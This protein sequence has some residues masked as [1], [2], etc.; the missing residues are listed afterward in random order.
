M[1]R[2]ST[3]LGS[4]RVVEAYRFEKKQDWV[5]IMLAPSVLARHVRPCNSVPITVIR[6]DEKTADLS[7][8]SI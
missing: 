5:G 7:D 4:S 6:S 1:L 8:L 3:Y 2:F